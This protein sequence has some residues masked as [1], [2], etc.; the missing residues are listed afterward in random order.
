MPNPRQP[1]ITTDLGDPAVYAVAIL[2]DNNA[3]V[4]IN[5]GVV[6]PMLTVM[7]LAALA[8]YLTDHIP[9]DERK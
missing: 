3:M 8:A 4:I 9:P 6:P 5:N 2:A 7:D 1:V